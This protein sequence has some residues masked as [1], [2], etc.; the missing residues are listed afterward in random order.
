[1]IDRVQHQDVSQQQHGYFYF[2]DGDHMKQYVGHAFNHYSEKM[3]PQ[4]VLIYLVEM[5]LQRDD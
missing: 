4:E 2:I 1:M 5:L 3:L